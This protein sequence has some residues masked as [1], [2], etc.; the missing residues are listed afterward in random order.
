MKC[1]TARSRA[2]TARPLRLSI[3]DEN[4]L[5]ECEISDAH[6][7]HRRAREARLLGRSGLQHLLRTLTEAQCAR[8]C[9]KKIME[10]EAKKTGASVRAAYEHPFL[11]RLCHWIN[12]VALLVLIASGLRIFRA[13]PSFGPKI[14]QANFV[15]CP[16][17]I[18]AWRLAR[19]R[20]AMAFHFPVDLR[21][22][23]PALHLLR[24]FQRELPP[25]AVHAARYSRRLADGAALFFL[26]SQAGAQRAV[27]S[28]AKAG[29]HFGHPSRRAVRPH[30]HGPLSPGAIL[31]AGPG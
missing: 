28:A 4:R 29:V 22:H 12:S 6:A 2:S 17:A 24:N 19:R 26:R 7:R 20:A 3:P 15:E 14:P 27:Q 18:H 16:G 8:H 25:G 10:W 23:R 5:Q 31:L 11:V 1:T 30:R 13:F 21:R 9:R